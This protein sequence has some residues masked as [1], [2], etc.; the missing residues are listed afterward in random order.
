MNSHKPKFWH[1]S[2]EDKIGFAPLNED[3]WFWRF[4]PLL[5]RLAN[6]DTGRDLLCLEKHPFPIVE[7]RKNTATYFL[8][9]QDGQYVFMADTRI[10]AKWANVIRYRWQ[11]FV[12]YAVRYG[13]WNQPLT[14]DWNPSLAPIAASPEILYPDAHPESTTADGTVT[15]TQ[16]AIWTTL[17]NGA[18]TSSRGD[19]ESPEYA[20][21]VT[22]IATANQ[23]GELYRYLL[24]FDS[25][26][27]SPGAVI[28]AATLSLKGESKI[29]A[30]GG[31]EVLNIYASAPAS[32]IQI[33]TGDFNSFGSTAFADTGITIASFSTSAY[34]AWVLNSSGLTHVTKAVDYFGSLDATYDAADSQPP[35]L[36]G[37]QSDAFK[38]HQADASGTASDPKLVI[39]YTL[40]FTP[41]LIM[42]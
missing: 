15:H 40:A 20:W 1:L 17:V 37:T 7:L 33:V 11:E 27:L 16:S 38:I 41:K 18:G 28:S 35:H 30:L 39:T 21:N 42:F 3:I 26:G 32:N 10:G 24:G 22:S 29:T 19:N 5:L 31:S 23:Y 8:G 36:G 6:T 4:Q 12:R 2:Y 25:S 14:K 13:G 9:E 34:N